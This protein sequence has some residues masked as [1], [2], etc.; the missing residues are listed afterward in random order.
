[1]TVHGSLT[2]APGRSTP[3]AARPARPDPIQR[4]RHGTPAGAQQAGTGE[5]GG[6]ALRRSISRRMLTVFVVGDVLG[7]GVYALIGE[8]AGEVGGAIWASFVLAMALALLTA[9]AYAELATKYPYAAGAALYVNRA[10][11]RSFVTFI[12]AFAVAMSGIASASTAT[13]AFGG[14][15]LAEFV[16]LPSALVAL[17]FIAV[18]AVINFVGIEESVKAN[19][20]FTT[21][22][23]GGLLLIA[24]G[25]A[26]WWAEP[27]IRGARSSSPPR[28][29][30]RW[31]SSAAPRWPSSPS[32]ASRTR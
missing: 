25:L 20:V 4:C 22:E 13:L 1:M 2:S 18:L 7:A 24:I 6:G 28:R 11:K 30:C 12:V 17:G 16:T 8:M 27:A 14:E 5:V 9:T 10:F 15:Y 32:L 26:P 3:S 23:V 21:I 19:A 29:R 31:R